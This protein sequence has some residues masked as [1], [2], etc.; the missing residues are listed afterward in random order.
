[1]AHAED[2]I[3]FL[4]NAKQMARL[5]ED[6]FVPE[7]VRVEKFQQFLKDQVLPF[8]T[9]QHEVLV[10]E[11]K[12]EF[13]DLCDDIARQSGEMLKQKPS[14]EQLFKSQELIALVLEIEEY[15]LAIERLPWRLGRRVSWIERARIR[16]IFRTVLRDLT[17]GRRAVRGTRIIVELCGSLARGESDWKFIENAGEIIPKPADYNL[18]ILQARFR[19]R[20]RKLDAAL[21]VPAALKPYM[22][23]V[24]ILV[25]NEVL[26][27]SIPAWASENGWSFKVG[28][29]YKKPLG[30]LL[31]KVH[32]RLLNTP[33]GGIRGR[34]V[35]YVVVRDLEGY[36]RFKSEHEAL[37]NRIRTELGAVVVCT[38][39]VILDEVIR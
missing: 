1:M 8:V 35:N 10:E 30:P 14:P 16:R 37:I 17:L 26:Y 6:Y 12:D 32:Q 7:R 20:Y 36:E 25:M 19:G 4:N 34:W 39:T 11:R 27:D 22:S 3:A 31:E 33:I 9:R 21:R 38:D 24:D 28:E 2:I 5:L 29:K 23:D 18:K 13:A 15:L